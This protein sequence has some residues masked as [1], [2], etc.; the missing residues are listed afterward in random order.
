[1]Y[2]TAFSAKTLPFASCGSVHR[3]FCQRERERENCTSLKGLPSLLQRALGVGWVIRLPSKSGIHVVYG[4]VF[5]LTFSKLSAPFWCH[6][7]I[8]HLHLHPPP[9]TTIIWFKN[10]IF[11]LQAKVIQ[12][13]AYCA[14]SLVL[15]FKPEFVS[16]Y[17]EK[18]NQFLPR[19]NLRQN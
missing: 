8:I 11:A 12:L 17:A 18:K 7:P 1:M 19:Q 15:T 6:S 4:T 14:M 10:N 5:S 13:T 16:S 3:C 2:A 9:Q